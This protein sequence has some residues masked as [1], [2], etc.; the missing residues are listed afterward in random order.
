M[1]R[2]IGEP[3]Q[4]EFDGQPLLVKR[5]GCP[6][7][8]SWRGETFTTAILLSEW[9]RYERRGDMAN[10]MSPA[11]ARAARLRGSRGV[12]RDYYK[13]RTRNDRVFTLYYDRSPKNAENT[14]GE[15][16]L[17]EEETPNSAGI[18]QD[19]DTGTD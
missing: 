13:I 7:R 2:F 16:I 5:A 19:A 8:F 4:V 18:P 14:L 10:N 9:H 6:V 1:R 3:I 12:G 11:H 15:W 17:L